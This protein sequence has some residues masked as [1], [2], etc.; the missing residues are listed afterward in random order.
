MLL[1]FN[2]IFKY[3][4]FPKGVIHV[5]MHRAEEYGYYKQGGVRDILFLEADIDLCKAVQIPDPFVK[6]VHAVV[7]DK[8][9]QGVTFRVTN[10][11]ESSSI[12]P[13]QDHASL[14][15]HIF[16]TEERHVVTTTLDEVIP[17]C[18]RS[19]YNILNFDIQGAELLAMKGYSSWELIDAVFT[20]VNF[21]GLYT[22]CPQMQE[23]TAFLQQQGLVLKEMEDTGMGWGD[24]LYVREKT[25]I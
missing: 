19:L 3:D 4:I 24:A 7:S 8:G 14:Y 16:V 5:G 6:I 9:G 17:E 18:Q 22:G 11:R 15:P 23:I 25:N 2:H 13:L 21:R 1:P 10:N 12:L 20:E